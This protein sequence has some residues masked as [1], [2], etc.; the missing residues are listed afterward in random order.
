MIGDGLN[1]DDAVGLVG[2]DF[3][4]HVN[5]GRW[6]AG[7]VIAY[8]D[9][10]TLVVE[11]PDGTQGHYVIGTIGDWSASDRP[12]G[13]QITQSPESL[14]VGHRWGT[15]TDGSAGPRTRHCERL[16]CDAT[17]QDFG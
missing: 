17:L 12:M 10:P 1:R 5:G 13:D 3:A 11:H 14:S 16:G 7:R 2:H 8:C 15:P 9:Q 6:V 4:G